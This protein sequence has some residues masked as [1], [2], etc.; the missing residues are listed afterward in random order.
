MDNRYTS[1]QQTA[2][3]AMDIQDACNLRGVLSAATDMARFIGADGGNPAMKADKAPEL[4]LMV[5]KIASLVECE[6]PSMD[7]FS[8]AW[9]ACEALAKSEPAQV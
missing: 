1:R 7:E 9:A 6:G 4:V 8:K 3:A 5:S 2:Q